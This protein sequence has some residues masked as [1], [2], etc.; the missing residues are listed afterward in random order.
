MSVGDEY[1]KFTLPV[2][3]DYKDKDTHFSA[4][5]IKTWPKWL[6]K[7]EAKLSESKGPFLLGKS[8]TLIDLVLSADFFKLSH[9]DAYEN[10]HILEAVIEQYPKVK[11]WIGKMHR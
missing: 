4:F 5:L 2:H 8:L 7:L 11:A 1:L 9:D 6:A 3:P 10:C